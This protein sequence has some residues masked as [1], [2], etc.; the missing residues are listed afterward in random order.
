M[1]PKS[2]SAAFL[3]GILLTLAPALAD[4]GLIQTGET[5]L[6]DPTF[7]RPVAGGPS[8]SGVQSHYN[9]QSFEITSAD[10]CYI[11]AQQNYDGY[12]HVYSGSF[13]PAAPL[14][15]LVAGDDDGDLSIGT[16]QLG[17]L[18]LPAGHYILVSSGFGASSVGVFTNAI[19]CES[20]TPPL[21]AP[22]NG[23]VV[24]GGYPNE[25]VLCLNDRFLVIIDN[26][27]N[28]TQGG[29]GVPVRFASKDTGLFWFYYPS[30]FEV[31]IKVLNGCGINNSWWVFGAA[32]TNQGFRIL[33]ADTNNPGLG[34]RPY[35][36]SFG[37]SAPAITDTVAFPCP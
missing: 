3:L 17:P 20:E 22:C 28:S 36:N 21:F 6:M 18:A 1:K 15:N 10:T 25:N 7:N 16:S 30:N 9:R 29:M 35:V 27:T 12:I 19:H 34:F 11:Y 5:T 13:N 2:V 37:V 32:L 23:F 8:L 33:V 4:G 26:V 31:M 24:G 14:S